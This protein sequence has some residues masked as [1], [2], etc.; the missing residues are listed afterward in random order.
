MTYTKTVTTITMEPS[1]NVSHM[2]TT[3]WFVP[4]SEAPS[5]PPVGA[6]DP[7]VV[8]RTMSLFGRPEAVHT[9]RRSLTEAFPLSA[10]IVK[11]AQCCFSPAASC[12]HAGCK[13]ATTHPCSHWNAQVLTCITALQVMMGL[14][15]GLTLT[16][17]PSCSA[18]AS[19]AHQ[20]PPLTLPEQATRWLPC[21]LRCRQVGSVPTLWA[22]N[23][24]VTSAHR[25][26]SPQ[27][28]LL[29][30]NSI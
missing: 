14:Q 28:A 17:P 7:A 23:S 26:F 24:L 11:H 19:T 16:I 5:L 22:Q 13:A 27:L 15:Q 25:A 4:C 3:S 2:Q 21:W 30:E 18:Q 1:G 9:G 10:L 20:R 29:V 8:T 12:T 6:P